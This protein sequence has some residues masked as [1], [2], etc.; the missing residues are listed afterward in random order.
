MSAITEN[1]PLDTRLLSDAIIELNI[2]RHNVS[3]YPRNHPIVEKS[4]TLAF[5][6]LKKLF[7]LRREITLAIAKDT[8]IIDD[9]S[10]DKQNPVYRDF[11]LCLSRMNIACIK[12]IQG[13]SE[14]EIYSFH[15][16]ILNNAQ[17]CSPEDIQKSFDEYKLKHIKIKL[18]DYAAFSFTGENGGQ[19]NEDG[20]IWERYIFGLLEGSLQTGEM[21]DAL[22]GMTPGK[23]AVLINSANLT[24]I[25]EESYDRVITS[26]VRSS[27]ER[28]FSDKELKKLLDFINGLR[29]ELKREF[30]SSSVNMISKDL[31]SVRKNRFQYQKH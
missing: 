31:A 29:P 7:E 12:F 15:S 19:F 20:L 3:T 2:S 13:L 23:L 25:K 24:N 8:L 27:S 14:N 22:Q 18:I 5:G 9:C 21:P 17:H 4:L 16:F 6:Y 10:L 1:L 30:L 28:A 11:A 26:Y